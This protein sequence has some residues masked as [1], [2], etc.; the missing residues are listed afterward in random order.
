MS[1]WQRGR[2]PYEDAVGERMAVDDHMWVGRQIGIL[3]SQSA[4]ALTVPRD[5]N[6]YDTQTAP[7]DEEEA[8]T[9]L[10]RFSVRSE[11]AGGDRALRG[12]GYF[13]DHDRTENSGD[14]YNVEP[15]AGRSHTFEV[16]A[17]PIGGMSGPNGVV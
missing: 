15:G 13:G 2:P 14:P 12:S 17:L 7:V 10:D 3:D 8:N 11:E 9:G 16:N 6:R 4:P 1:H 5:Q